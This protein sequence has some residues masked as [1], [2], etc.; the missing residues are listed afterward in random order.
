[1]NVNGWNLFFGPQDFEA[2]REKLAKDGDAI[3]QAPESY[4]C[5][6]IAAGGESVLDPCYPVYVYVVEAAV[7]MNAANAATLV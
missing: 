1:M 5:L 2:W 3:Y 7:L 6:A 4:P